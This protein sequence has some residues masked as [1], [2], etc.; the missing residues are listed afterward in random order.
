MPTVGPKRQPEPEKLGPNPELTKYIQQLVA[1][2]YTTMTRLAEAVDMSLSAFSRGIRE[3][4]TLSAENCLRLAHEVGERPGVI[5]RLCNRGDFADIADALYGGK[6]VLSGKERELLHLWRSAEDEGAKNAARYTLQ[7][8]ATTAKLRA[9]LMHAN[10]T[11]PPA[12]KKR[13]RRTAHKPE[14]VS[15]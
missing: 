3:E 12:G 11:L 13:R 7:L 5:L 4:G 10:V 1:E 9:A 2:R 14:H 15:G 8:A 6:E